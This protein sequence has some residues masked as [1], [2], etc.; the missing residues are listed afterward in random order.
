M[1]QMLSNKE[2][3]VVAAGNQDLLKLYNLPSKIKE[4]GGIK[5]IN[6]SMNIAFSNEVSDKE[7]A[8]LKQGLDKIAGQLRKMY[9]DRTGVKDVN[10]QINTQRTSNFKNVNTNT[11]D[12][13]I[14]LKR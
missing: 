8:G 5:S 2:A 13:Q 1:G 3:T 4:D 12:V 7:Y 11:P 10:V 9:Q 14:N 6:I